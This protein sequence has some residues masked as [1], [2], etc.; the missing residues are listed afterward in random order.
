MGVQLGHTEVVFLYLTAC[1]V[2]PSIFCSFSLLAKICLVVLK[3][4]Q[5]LP[6]LLKDGMSMTFIEAG[7][8]IF[9]QDSRKRKEA[10]DQDLGK[11][12]AHAKVRRE[13]AFC[14]E[15]HQGK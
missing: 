11:S 6:I 2:T 3:L 10:G 14:E 9:P 13:T 12:A 15:Q 1:F 4:E 5:D 8:L 7:G